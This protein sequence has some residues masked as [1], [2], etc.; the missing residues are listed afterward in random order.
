MFCCLLANRGNRVILKY[1]KKSLIMLVLIGSVM[2]ASAQF[3][4]FNSQPVSVTYDQNGNVVGST[5]RGSLFGNRFSISNGYGGLQNPNGGGSIFGILNNAQ[6]LV[7]RLVPF[8]VGLAVLSFF[9][10]LVVFIWKGDESAE[11]RQEGMK[12]MG[13]SLFAIFLMVS[14]WGVIGLIGS[15]IGVGQG[16]G[17]NQIEM[18]RA[19]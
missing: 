13:Y 6:L 7:T 12:G 1:M 14:I 2:F 17:I 18:P 5:V 10:Y 16:G 19:R 9:W 3:T 8:T 11:K 15:I 4:T